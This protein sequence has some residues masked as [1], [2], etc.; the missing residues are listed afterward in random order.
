MKG[1]ESFGSDA[2]DF[3]ILVYNYFNNWPS[4]WEDFCKILEKLS[5]PSHRFLKHVSSRWLTLEPAA[6]QLLEQWKCLDFLQYIPSRK[7]RRVLNT[8]SYK[9]IV[10]YL[11]EKAIKC[12]LLFIL[13]SAKLFTQYTSIFQRE[14][15]FNT[16]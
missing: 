4:R 3:I 9:R 11:K 1:L 16:R 5:V 13:S 2:S 10:E 15:P 14:D 6:N 7:E 8:V 12:Q